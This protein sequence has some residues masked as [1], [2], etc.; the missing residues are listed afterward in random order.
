MHR[1]F[2]PVIQSPYTWFLRRSDMGRL[3]P[4]VGGCHFSNGITVYRKQFCLVYI[5]YEV[6]QN[7]FITT[8]QYDRYAVS[9]Y[10]QLA[11][12]V[13]SLSKLTAKE[14]SKHHITAKLQKE[15]TGGQWIPHKR[16]SNADALSCYDV[17]Q[18]IFGVNII[19]ISCFVKL[20]YN[21]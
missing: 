12:L 5:L 16:P 14:T 8:Y 6:Y 15:S 13:N 3:M 21:N 18:I 17:Y 20:V 7:H 2:S 10:Q 4:V 1:K 9:N 19:I 11:C